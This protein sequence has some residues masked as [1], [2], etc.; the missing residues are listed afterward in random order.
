MDEYIVAR[1]G[2]LQ[3]TH[4]SLTFCYIFADGA[5]L[6]CHSALANISSFKIVVHILQRAEFISTDWINV[7]L[8]REKELDVG[9]TMGS[10]FYTIRFKDRIRIGLYFYS[11]LN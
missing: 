1:Q 8:H 11:F 5:L 3:G 6:W 7:V 4:M 2:K 10:E 9:V